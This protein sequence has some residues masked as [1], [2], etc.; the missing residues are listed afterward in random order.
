M[1]KSHVWHSFTYN[2]L[3][4]KKILSCV[5]DRHDAEVSRSLF[6][7]IVVAIFL[8]PH[9]SGFETHV[10]VVHRLAVMCAGVR[11]VC[12]CVWCCAWVLCGVCVVV[13]WWCVCGV[14]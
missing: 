8:L 11:V 13:L 2:A 1:G 7:P 3:C 4:H 10:A 9:A 14:W 6:K 5:F 12:V